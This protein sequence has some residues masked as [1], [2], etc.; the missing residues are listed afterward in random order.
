MEQG[1]KIKM[2]ST[3]A[4]DETYCLLPIILALGSMVKDETN[5]SIVH[6]PYSNVKQIK[7]KN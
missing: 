5:K 3:D 4:T 2:Y 1:I 6:C 7:N